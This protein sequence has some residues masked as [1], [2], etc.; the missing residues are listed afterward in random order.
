MTPDEIGRV[1]LFAELGE[2][3]REQVSRL[4]ADISLVAGEYAAHEGGEGAL[5]AVLEGK[6]EPVKTTD[7]IERVVGERLPG[8]IF[9][10]VPMR[11]APSSPSA[12][13][14]PWTR[15]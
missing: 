15:A 14:R 1:D 7:G 8:S 3:Q 2:P 4:A 12:S 6:I 5:F 9:G 11:S 13:A 10:E